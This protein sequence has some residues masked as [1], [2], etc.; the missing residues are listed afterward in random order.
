MFHRRL[1]ATTFLASSVLIAPFAYADNVPPSA[2]GAKRI[3][4]A[5]QPYLGPL[6]QGD[7]PLLT[8]SPKGDG[9][10]VSFDV[11]AAANDLKAVLPPS[12]PID[13]TVKSAPV[14]EMLFEQ[15]DGMWKVTADSDL[16]MAI[17]MTTRQPT[18]SQDQ[19]MSMKFKGMKYEAIFDP[20]LMSA[21]HATMTV[22]QL[23]QTGKET[24]TVT[25]EGVSTTSPVSSSQQGA[26]PMNQTWESSAAGAD[27]ID[28]KTRG[29]RE[30]SVW[31]ME[32]KPPAAADAQTDA[33]ID[34]SVAHQDV[35]ANVSAFHNQKLFAL[36]AFFIAYH[37][38]PDIAAHEE[39]LK[40][41]LHGLGSV[42]DKIEEQGIMTDAK[43][44][45]SNATL[46]K[47]ADVA[48]ANAQI[49]FNTTGLVQQ[50]DMSVT[51]KADGMS[52]TSSVVPAWAQD[53]IPN[54]FELPLRISDHNLADA[55][56]EAI[57]DFSLQGD[58][59]FTSEQ[60]MMI[61]VNALPPTGLK[62]ALGPGRITSK[63]LDIE[64]DGA[65]TVVFPTPRGSVTLK[66]HGLDAALDAMQKA[67][68]TD[69]KAAQFEQ[70]L[71]TAKSLAKTEADGTATWVFAYDQ[72]G[73]FS[74]N[75]T[76]LN[77]PQQ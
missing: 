18:G 72:S 44:S 67:A 35:N 43:L 74:V 2:D 48:I 63:L 27:T 10:V 32:F 26:G 7:H 24:V 76:V 25:K 66:A 20:K 8:V 65:V 5:L 61:G 17:T 42:F 16:D 55:A 38:K 77:H 13:F 46:G 53:L 49:A 14:Q 47:I 11:E 22:E 50:G 9:Y 70:A 62:V 57:D 12:A 3:A 1:L 68:L 6:M 31:H 54:S 21:T 58:E 19:T 37:S 34:M 71:E 40:D 30:N 45:V 75:G 51:M 52:L 64:M 29:A 33:T 28:M 23:A 60:A 59:P 15:S 4:D 39:E 41:L 36:I 69:P 56:N 73:V